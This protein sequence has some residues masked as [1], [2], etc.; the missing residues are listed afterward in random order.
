M[1]LICTGIT[2]LLENSRTILIFKK[3]ASWRVVQK[4]LMSQR[5]TAHQH[6]SPIGELASSAG[7]LEDVEGGSKP[8]K[9]P[10]FIPQK[11]WRDG[12][13]PIKS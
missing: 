12:E 9:C 13:V 3:L 6:C 8:D 10:F 11:P 5:L 2:P 7:A 4:V 1:T